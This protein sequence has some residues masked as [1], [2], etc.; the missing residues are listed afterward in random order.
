MT[1]S[2]SAMLTT[3]AA[4]A[5]PAFAMTASLLKRADRLL[6]R[7]TLCCGQPLVRVLRSLQTVREAIWPMD[8]PHSREQLANADAVLYFASSGL[9]FPYYIGIAEYLKAHFDCSSLVVAGVSG[10]YAPAAS[11]VLG[12]DPETHWR[13]IDGMRTMGRS[14]ALGTY[15][16]SEHEMMHGGYLPLLKDDEPRL[17]PLLSSKRLWLGCTRLWPQPLRA[18]WLSSFDS[19]HAL[20]HACTCSMRVLPILRLP[21]KLGGC[22]VVDGFFGCHPPQLAC[23]EHVLVISAVPSAAGLSPKE[24]LGGAT[25]LVRLPSRENFDAW[26][27]QGWLDASE[28]GRAHWERLRLKPKASRSD[29]GNGVGDRA[30]AGGH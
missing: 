19:L 12:L 7:S 23:D 10:G 30:C 24:V 22:W 16:F 5:I 4:L 15:F 28:R 2:A 8:E 3:L 25:D 27:R 14:R 18:F 17:L 1:N 9:F 26:M 6:L 29:T 13:A 11:I 21:G 20:V